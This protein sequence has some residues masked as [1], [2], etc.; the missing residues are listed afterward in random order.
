MVRLALER[1]GNHDYSGGVN[2]TCYECPFA[3]VPLDAA[4]RPDPDVW[5]DPTEAYFRCSLPGRDNE[6]VVWGEY[7]PCTEGEWRKVALEALV[8]ASTVERFGPI[9]RVDAG[10]YRA[11]DRDG[12]LV[13]ERADTLG[14]LREVEWESDEQREKWE[15]AVATGGSAQA[16][17]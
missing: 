16:K 2:G 7:A 12:V 8:L 14:A 15:R 5:N 10:I 17:R 6:A 3:T 1:L 4:G 11:V 13:V 9:C